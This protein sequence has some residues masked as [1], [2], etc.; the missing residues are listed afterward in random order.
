MIFPERYSENL[1]IDNQED[2]M[3][4]TAAEKKYYRSAPNFLIQF[5]RFSV[6]YGN[7]IARR[8]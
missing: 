3:Y 8:R 1:K 4:Q 7:F 6:Y 2:N 5:W